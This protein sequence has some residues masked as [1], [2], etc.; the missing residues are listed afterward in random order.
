MHVKIVDRNFDRLDLYVYRNFVLKSRNG[1]LMRFSGVFGGFSSI[2][3]IC[4]WLTL[5]E[6][7][8]LGFYGLDSPLGWT[9]WRQ[10]HI[11]IYIYIHIHIYIYIH[12]Y[13]YIHILYTYIYIYIFIY[14]Y[15]Y[16]NICVYIYIY[17]CVC[18]CIYI[19]IYTYIYI[20]V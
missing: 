16:I 9:V 3:R 2:P 18:V 14:I 6:P 15:M 7:C 10:L 5:K 12:T 13:I 20:Y 8:T 19:Y 4:F 1:F 17:M 11:P